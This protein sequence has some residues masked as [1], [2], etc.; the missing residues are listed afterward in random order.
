MGFGDI[1]GSA[2]AMVSPS[3]LM[4]GISGALSGGLSGMLGMSGGSC[5]ASAGSYGSEKNSGANDPCGANEDPFKSALLEIGMN[6]AG[7]SIA[8]LGAT[9]GGPYNMG[10]DSING[11]ISSIGGSAM[12][13]ALTDKLG[14]SPLA[15]SSLS[16]PEVPMSDL[17][18]DISSAASGT[19]SF[20]GNVY[21][22]VS[23]S[24]G[25]GDGPVSGSSYMR[26]L[27]ETI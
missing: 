25:W 6:A 9:L 16:T 26:P 20:F 23:N 8:S 24:S 3:G 12:G 15:S 4:G 17:A 18:S 19:A 11:G 21:D 7:P 5:P 13:G 10:V 22:N 1:L 2:A 14:V 27:D